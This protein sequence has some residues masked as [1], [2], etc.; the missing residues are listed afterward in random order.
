MDA[1]EQVVASLLERE[2]FW[3]RSSVKVNLTKQEKRA[4][5]RA[6]SPRWELDLVAYKGKTNELW[7]VECKSYLDSGGVS[8]SAFN[9]SNQRFA[10]RFKLFNERKLFQTVSERVCSQLI[11]SG[12]CR[13]K[14]KVRL[15]LAAGRVA[16]DSQRAE[17]HAL[18]KRRGW[19]LWDEAELRR[20]LTSLSDESYENAV[21]SVVSKLLLR[22]RKRHRARAAAQG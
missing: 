16:T 20:R 17:L 6:S 2:G 3:V 12:A 1:F 21:A 5:G 14:P 4:I 13:V 10:D 22:Q 18:F 9:G 19:L 11:A 15:V 8:I 7:I